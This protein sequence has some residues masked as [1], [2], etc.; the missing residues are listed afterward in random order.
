[1]DGLSINR[2][3]GVK[4]TVKEGPEGSGER[5]SVERTVE[6]GRASTRDGKKT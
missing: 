5:E 1:M 2:Y 4:I 6:I 3:V